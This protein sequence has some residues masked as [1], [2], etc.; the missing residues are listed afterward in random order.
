MARLITKT[1]GAGCE[2]SYRFIDCNWEVEA[3]LIDDLRMFPSLEEAE[4]AYIKERGF[5]PRWNNPD[6][7]VANKGRRRDYYHEYYLAHK[8]KRDAQNRKWIKEHPEQI[9]EYQRKY[10]EKNREKVAEYH[11]EYAKA[12]REQINANAKAWRAKK[13]QAMSEAGETT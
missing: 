3:C 2:T 10:R 7:D 4:A 6:R 13:R 5:K 1:P 9:R 12:H 8:E 11:R